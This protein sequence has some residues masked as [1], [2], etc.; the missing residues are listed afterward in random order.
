MRYMMMVM[1]DASYEA[2]EPPSDAL[3]QGMGAYMGKCAQEGILVDGAGLQPSGKGFKAKSRKGEISIV[4]GPFT[5]A[6]EIVGGYAIV[7]VR[8]EAHAREVV[9]E[10]IQVHID[11]G[12]T[13]VDCEIRPLEAEAQPQ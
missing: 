2:G 12:V 3:L 13:D 8:D 1:G 6:K 7:D 9:R 4:D 10:F 11:A 5:E